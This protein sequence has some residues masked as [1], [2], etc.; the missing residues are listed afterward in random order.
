[1]MIALIAAMT[2]DRVA[3]SDGTMPWYLPD[4]QIRDVMLWTLEC[5]LFTKRAHRLW[6]DR[7]DLGRG[8]DTEALPVCLDAA[9]N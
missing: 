1:M 3:G 5:Q 8:R 4:E 9:L 2:R 6:R 7:P